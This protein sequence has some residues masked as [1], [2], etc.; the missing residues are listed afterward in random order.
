MQ[1]TH[2]W[3]ELKQHCE[4]LCTIRKMPLQVLQRQMDYFSRDPSADKITMVRSE[5]EEVRSVFDS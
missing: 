1:E 4:L 5:I 3:T 2:A